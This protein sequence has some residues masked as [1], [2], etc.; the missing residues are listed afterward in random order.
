M[1]VKI[2][3]Y[4]SFI[5]LI[6]FNSIAQTE[7]YL[8]ENMEKI[9]SLTFKKKCKVN[10][11]KCLVYKTDSLILNKILYKY[12]FGKLT[13]NELEQVKKIVSSTSKF[14]T[15][16][17]FMINFRDT[18]YNYEVTKTRYDL[19]VKKHQNVKHIPYS[20]EK[21]NKQRVQWVKQKKK[22]TKKI[23]SKYNTNTFYTYK[24]DFGVNNEY[25]GIHW[26]KDTGILKKIFF[27]I[28]YNYRYVVVKPSGD[29]FACGSYLSNKKLKQL[30]KNNSWKKYIL[31]L[32]KSYNT[33]SKNG[34][35]FFKKENSYYNSQC[36]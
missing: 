23:N 15:S 18:L 11:L 20:L 6:S 5:F 21:Y 3:C 12:Q 26:I 1:I 27:N 30:L 16:N 14:N 8:D 36:F 19:H 28:Q 17:N 4:I 33:E 29:Y 13:K 32:E 24:F 7:F 25:S 34:I 22:C 2:A 31:D 10:V 35:G 9:D